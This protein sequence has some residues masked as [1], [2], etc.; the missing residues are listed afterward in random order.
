MAIHWLAVKQEDKFPTIATQP[1]LRKL[2]AADA[3]SF[4]KYQGVRHMMYSRQNIRLLSNA[5]DARDTVLQ[6]AAMDEFNVV[7]D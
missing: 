3:L 5:L 1:E 7:W 2:T 6:R 4:G